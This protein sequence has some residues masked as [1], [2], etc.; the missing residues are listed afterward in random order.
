MVG[1]TMA[2]GAV[3]CDSNADG[4]QTTTAPRARHALLGDISVAAHDTTVDSVPYEIERNCEAVGG[5]FEWDGSTTIFLE[6][7]P[8]VCQPGEQESLNGRFGIFRTSDNASVRQYLQPAAT[9]I[10]DAEVFVLNYVE[11]TNSC[12]DIP[13]LA[14][15]ITLDE[16]VE[17]DGVEYDVLNWYSDYSDTQVAA[18][19]DALNTLAR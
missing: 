2:I 15:I 10:G 14:A 18:M 13:K 16:P 7:L 12:R 11:C 17:V 3:G 1:L 6:A 19:Y 9:A 5:W 4:P 8:V